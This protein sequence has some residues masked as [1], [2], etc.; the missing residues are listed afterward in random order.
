LSADAVVSARGK[1]EIILGKKILSQAP[2]YN[3]PL[4]GGLRTGASAY[5]KMFNKQQW[6]FGVA[7]T[8]L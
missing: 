7:Y 6:I 8:Q 5:T 2:G 4:S 1:N 3:L